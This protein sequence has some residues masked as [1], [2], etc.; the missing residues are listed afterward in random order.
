VP[1]ILTTHTGSLPRPADLSELMLARDRGRPY[2]AAALER[3]IVSATAEVVKRQVEAGID[4]VSDGEFSKTSYTAYVKDRLNGFEGEQLQVSSATRDKEEFPDFY[5]DPGNR[6]SMPSCNGPVS[7][8]DPSAVRRDIATFQAA[9]H[10]SGHTAGFMTSPSPGQI[11]RFMPT[12]YYQTD[13]EYLYALAGAMQDEY[14]AIVQAGLVL[15]LD[16]PD[17]ASGRANQFAHLGIDDFRQIVRLHVDVLNHALHGLPEDR[18]RLHLCWGNYEGPHNHDVPLRDIVGEVLRA[19]VGAILFEAANPRHAHEWKLWRDV[20]LP[21]DKIVVPGVIDS[22][23][24]YIEHPELVA[25]RLRHFADLLGPDRVMA[26]SDCGFGTSL[27]VRKVAPSIAW[28]KLEAMVEG[29][30]LASAESPP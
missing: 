19:N 2:D 7:L 11:A 5:R 16:C 15:Q 23:S 20:E 28:A 30:R 10:A 29:A 17:L 8:R 1:R 6:V 22:C 4:L 13:E 21:D 18:L 9:L 24:N 27:G 26:G 3:R 14:R 12:T 25:E